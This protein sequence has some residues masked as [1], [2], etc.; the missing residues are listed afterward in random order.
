MRT[1]SALSDAGATSPG[2][3][4]GVSDADPAGVDAQALV[5]LG[6]ALD[7]LGAGRV[8]GFAE[9]AVL[10][11]AFPR[12]AVWRQDNGRLWIAVRPVARFLPGQRR[13]RC[14]CGQ[15]RPPS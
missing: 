6:E 1:G 12:W 8:R 4:T 5:A 9:V 2:R 10:A 7:R 14:G 11:R 13:R 3:S 15:E